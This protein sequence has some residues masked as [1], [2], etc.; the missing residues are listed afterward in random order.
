MEINMIDRRNFHA[1]AAGLLLGVG[2]A[3]NA[4][5]QTLT[6]PGKSAKTCPAP[7]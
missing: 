2:G 7:T 1:L 6:R 3:F 5:A 4:Q